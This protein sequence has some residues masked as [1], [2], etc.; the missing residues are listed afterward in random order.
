MVLFTV[1][2]FSQCMV[3]ECGVGVPSNT[4]LVCVVLMPVYACW[5]VVGIDCDGQMLQ[6][7]C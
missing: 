7:L 2:V 1:G 3:I 6:C 4:W 5:V